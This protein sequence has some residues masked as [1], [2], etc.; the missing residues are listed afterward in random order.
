MKRLVNWTFCLLL[1][2]SGWG[3]GC[4]SSEDIPEQEEIIDNSSE[5]GNEISAYLCTDNASREAQKV[6]TYLRNCWGKKMLS[7]T[8]ANV[9]WNIN[10]AVWVKRHVGKYPAIAC[11]DY[12][13]LPSSSY[14]NLSNWQAKMV[15][16]YNQN[17]R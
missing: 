2:C 10:E 17:K 5:E 16:S 7:S 15:G 12:M 3:V 13:N 6:Y 8:M 11:F 1:I 9:D 14:H 4:S